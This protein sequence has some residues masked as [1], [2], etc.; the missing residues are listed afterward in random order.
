[1]IAHRLETRPNE[2]S[3]KFYRT[4]A[5]TF[6]IVAVGLFGL[7]ILLTTKSA[8]IT[9]LAKNDASVVN[10]TLTLTPNPTP[11][12]SAT[13]AGTVSSSVRSFSASFQPTGNQS[14]DAI[15]GGDVILYNTQN[16]A[17]TLVKT[18]RLLTP[19]GVQFR[20]KN[21]ITIPANGQI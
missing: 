2:P 17:Q 15:A 18:T 14:V 8:T 13:I 3:V 16:S 1:M 4:I 9:I 5:V 10:L 12:T 6:L 19:A 11:G 21:T 20:L 7:V